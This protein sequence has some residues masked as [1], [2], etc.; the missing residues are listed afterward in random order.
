MIAGPLSGLAAT[1]WALFPAP[2]APGDPAAVVAASCRLPMSELAPATADEP[3]VMLGGL[4]DLWVERLGPA[5]WRGWAVTDRGPNGMVDVDG[6]E[7]RTLLAPSFA[8]RIVE[9]EIE[10]DAAAPARVRATVTGTP[11]LR[12][13]EGSPLSGRPNGLPGDPEM[14]DPRGEASIATDPRGVDT[15][16]LVRLRSGRWWL[17]EEYGP[18]LLVAAADG[19]VDRRLVP[20][21]KAAAAS[22]MDV[23]ECLPAAYAGRRDN[24]GFEALAIAPDESRIF[25][26]LQSP[27]PA[28]RGKARDTSGVVRLLVLDPATGLPA[29]EHVYRLGNDPT[30]GSE[31]IPDDG[32]L[33]AMAALGPELLLVLE[34]ADGGVVR[35]Y[36]ADLSSATDT[37]PRTLAG[38]EPALEAIDLAAAG[39]VPVAK[40]LAADIGPIVDDLRAGVGLGD[41]TAALKIE[42]LAVADERHVFLVNDDDFGVRGAS[43]AP[44]P[45]SCLWVLRLPEPLPLSNP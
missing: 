29:A 30:A 43:A 40:R 3:A 44:P 39:V 10:W 34:Q 17:A 32:K 5:R 42:G 41:S 28:S 36:T 18:S 45:G 12:D 24:R 37:L 4:S 26:L 1:I 11:A 23:R 20:V 7:R 8:P 15:E 6:R 13:R 22:G 25:A 2:A 33:C 21:G 31:G 27:L 9:L 16:G 35:L 38:D 19:R 14:L